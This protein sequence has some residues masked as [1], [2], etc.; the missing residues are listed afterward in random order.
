MAADRE[1]ASSAVAILRSYFTSNKAAQ[2]RMLSPISSTGGQLPAGSFI[3]DVINSVEKCKAESETGKRA[4]QV[5]T[6]HPVNLGRECP[7]LG[8]LELGARQCNSPEFI[9]GNY[10]RPS[11]RAR[12]Q[13]TPLLVMPAAPHITRCKGHVQ[14]DGGAVTLRAVWIQRW[15][16]SCSE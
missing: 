15:N 6:G 16:C 11:L 12:P 8:P 5:M 7:P 3:S 1:E 10:S 13:S 2:E 14:V 9:C 4:V